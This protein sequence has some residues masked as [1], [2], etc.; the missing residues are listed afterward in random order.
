MRANIRELHGFCSGRAHN[1]SNTVADPDSS[2]AVDNIKPRLMFCLLKSA[3]RGTIY[4]SRSLIPV[5]P[6]LI[7][8][9]AVITERSKVNWAGGKINFKIPPIII[10]SR[11]SR[12]TDTPGFL[13]AVKLRWHA[14]LTLHTI[15]LLDAQYMY[16]VYNHCG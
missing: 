5:D 4:P 9:S 6:S 15:A 8:L 2:I 16:N 10:L 13:C 3:A 14:E 1:V 12:Y 7:S 11:C